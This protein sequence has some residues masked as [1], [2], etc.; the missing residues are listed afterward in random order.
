[1]GTCGDE[2]LRPRIYPRSKTLQSSRT[3]ERQISRLPEHDLVD[4][5]E[6]G[7]PDDGIADGSCDLL[8]IGHHEFQ[9]LLHDRDAGLRQQVLGNPG[10]LR[11]RIDQELFRQRRPGWLSDVHDFTIDV[12]STHVYTLYT[13]RAA[14][15]GYWYRFARPIP[16]RGF[17]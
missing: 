4:G 8:T 12:E 6:A 9:V 15:A 3:Q 16:G 11:A 1:M 17:A 5:L 2:S 14:P 10:V 7:R 13:A